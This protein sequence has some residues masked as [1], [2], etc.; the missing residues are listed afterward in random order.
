MND[1]ESYKV[2]GGFRMSATGYLLAALFFAGG[3]IAPQRAVYT[4]PA[5][6]RPQMSIQEAKRVI[7]EKLQGVYNSCYERNR[8][9]DVRVTMKGFS[10]FDP[11]GVP[12][13]GA[14]ANRPM[15]RSFD[16]QAINSVGVDYFANWHGV[17]IVKINKEEILWCGSRSEATLFT[18][19]L[20]TMK[21]YLT[22]QI[23]AD[24]AVPFARFQ[25]EARAWRA[26]PVKPALPETVRRSKLLAEDAI[27]NRKFEEAV[28]HYEQGLQVAP[29]WPEGQFNA[30]L[31]YGELEIYGQAVLHMKRYL[32]L[33][34]D[35]PDAPAARDQVMIWQ[36]KL[37]PMPMASP[38][39]DRS[40]PSEGKARKRSK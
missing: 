35:A 30:A 17:H 4:P 33:N 24:D 23:L 9:Q 13:F 1:F 3:C 7:P 25:E 8:Y 28:D 2:G 11:G 12:A 18:D 37:P 32:E 14:S 34:P 10:Y 22:G 40:H 21:Y 26:L 31:I 36:A 5:Q 15:S 29:L 27:K 39:P 38:E 19:A 16:F 6:T 20:L